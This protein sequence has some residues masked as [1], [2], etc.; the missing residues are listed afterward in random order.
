MPRYMHVPERKKTGAARNAGA[1][2]LLSGTRLHALDDAG[3]NLE[4]VVAGHAGLAGHAGGDD[5]DIGALER[6]S[7]LLLAS[8]A[9]RPGTRV[10]VTDV[11]SHAGGAGDI[12]QRQLADVR[13]QLRGGARR[14]S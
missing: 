9:R 4:Q 5:D 1:R 6:V 3:V 12:V 2:W 11:G 14:G 8:V 7:Q 13:R 10:D